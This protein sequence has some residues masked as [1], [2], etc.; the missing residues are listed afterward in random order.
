MCF[1][2]I[3]NLYYSLLALLVVVKFNK[4]FIL[5]T[6]AAAINLYLSRSH[7]HTYIYIYILHIFSRLDVF[8]V[9]VIVAGRQTQSHQPAHRVRDTHR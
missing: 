1:I 5:L 8:V 3:L 4:S 9:F 7:N 6:R 2:V